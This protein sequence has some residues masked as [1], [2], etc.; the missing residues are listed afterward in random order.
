MMQARQDGYRRHAISAANRSVT[1]NIGT[2]LGDFQ[3][4]ARA[5]TIVVNRDDG[6]LAFKTHSLL[7]N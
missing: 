3:H 7:P 1:S 6:D 5:D 4:D 2:L